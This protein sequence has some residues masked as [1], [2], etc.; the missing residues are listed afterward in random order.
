MKYEMI[1]DQSTHAIPFILH[2][3]YFIFSLVCSSRACI[4]LHTDYAQGVLTISPHQTQ[5]RA[6]NTRL[7]CCFGHCE[8]FC[9]PPYGRGLSKHF[10]EGQV[11]G[12]DHPRRH[13][14]NCRF[15]VRVHT[16]AL[17]WMSE[18]SPR[19]PEELPVHALLP[20]GML[21]LQVWFARSNLSLV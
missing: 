9:A 7:R 18:P 11:L 13:P 15:S 14:L 17:I 2:T 12:R 21:L 10:T 20:A 4:L 16:L 5:N 19:Q 6:N 3:S 1:R 8:R